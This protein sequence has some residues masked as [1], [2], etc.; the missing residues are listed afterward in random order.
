M[1]NVALLQHRFAIPPDAV[2][3]VF[4]STGDQSYGV[5]AREMWRDESLANG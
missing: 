3:A 2:A 4:L 5:C 1:A